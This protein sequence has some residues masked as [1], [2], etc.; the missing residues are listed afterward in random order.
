MMKLDLVSVYTF[1]TILRRG[2]VVMSMTYARKDIT[3]LG[4]CYSILRQ[5][6]HTDDFYFKTETTWEDGSKQHFPSIHDIYYKGKKV[7]FVSH[8]IGN[9][10]TETSITLFL[11]ACHDAKLVTPM[12]V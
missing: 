12:P 1:R 5:L 11:D 3:N 6:W 7:G 2:L 8:G 4:D 9:P 10:D